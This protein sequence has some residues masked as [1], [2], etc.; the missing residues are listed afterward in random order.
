MLSFF[1]RPSH[2]THVI[3][4][5]SLN[6]ADQERRERN[7]D[8]KKDQLKTTLHNTRTFYYLYT[9]KTVVLIIIYSSI[10]LTLVFDRTDYRFRSKRTS[11]ETTFDRTDLLPPRRTCHSKPSKRRKR[12]SHFT[13]LFIFDF[14]QVS[15]TCSCISYSRYTFIFFFSVHVMPC[16]KAC[17]FVVLR[18]IL[19]WLS[20]LYYALLITCSLVALR[21][22][23]SLFTIH[24][25]PCF[26]TYSFLALRTILSSLSNYNMPC[27]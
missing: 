18:A 24:V 8:N 3:A 14:S 27:W 6:I 7:P 13:G 10:E 22:V 15:Y 21:A 25:A 17:S 20:S 9:C 16:F 2:F 4:N 26:E 11:I 23:F 19:S 5:S 12:R 1:W